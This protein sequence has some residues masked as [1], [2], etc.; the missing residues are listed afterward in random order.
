V[1]DETEALQKADLV[2]ASQMSNLYA[3]VRSATEIFVTL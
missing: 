3:L 1:I 2:P